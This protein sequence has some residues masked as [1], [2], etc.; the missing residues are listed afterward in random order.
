M[1]AGKIALYTV[2]GAAVGTGAGVGLI[3]LFKMNKNLKQN[4]S[5]VSLIKLGI[6][7]L[8]FALIIKLFF[9]EWYFIIIFLIFLNGLRM[10]IY[11]EPLNYKN[12]RFV[13]II[14]IILM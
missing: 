7:G 14:F 3:V 10:I 4:I 12:M 8:Y 6:I 11:H 9:G 1:T 2:G 5:I 13:G